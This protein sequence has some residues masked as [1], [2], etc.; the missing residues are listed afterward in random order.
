MAGQFLL[1]AGRYTEA[2]EVLNKAFSIDPGFWVAHIMMGQIYER[3]GKPEAAI[4]SFEKAYSLSA[5]NTMALSAKGYV[6]ART[7]RHAEAEQIVHDL[8]EAGKAR[9]VPPYN[10][11]LVYE[12]LGN[13]ESALEWLAKAYET[14]DVQMVFLPIDPKWNGLRSD[15]RFTELLK[16]CHFVRSR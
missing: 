3:S 11:A 16:R 7:G 1:H 13:R 10:I 5:G 12:G 9:Y 4:Q 2:V 14:R 8:M 15:F 6:L